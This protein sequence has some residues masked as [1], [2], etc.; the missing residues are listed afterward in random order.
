M[1]SCHYEQLLLAHCQWKLETLEAGYQGATGTT[2]HRQLNSTVV[3]YQLGAALSSFKHTFQFQISEVCTL[4]S[5]VDSRHSLA[6]L[7]AVS[8]G[9]TVRSQ[10]NK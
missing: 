7:L 3:L 8:D 6:V 1:H 5:R 2:K 10:I 4:Y 9:V